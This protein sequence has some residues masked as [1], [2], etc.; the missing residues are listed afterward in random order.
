MLG[1]V[2]GHAGLFSNAN[3][4]AKLMQMY[5]WKGFYGGER[6][7]NPD[8]LDLF[9]TCYF[10]DKNV[11]RGVGFGKPQLGTSGPTCGCVSMTSF[12][13]SGFTGTFAWADPE[14]E[15][16]YVFLSN[17]TF[18]DAENRKLIQTDLRSKIQEAIY[19]AIDY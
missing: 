16:V 12:G 11:R 6:Y 9:N 8:V 5:L 18:P 1:G 4:V 13:H 15:I 10:C 7:F 19:E 2:S 14:A 3:D 17:R